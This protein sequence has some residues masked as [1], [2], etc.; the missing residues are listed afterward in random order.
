MPPNEE[1][2]KEDIIMMIQ[3]CLL[4]VFVVGATDVLEKIRG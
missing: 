1:I 2:K 3:L 4:L